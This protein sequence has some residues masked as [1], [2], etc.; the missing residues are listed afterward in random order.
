M[1]RGG[2]WEQKTGCTELLL[3]RSRGSRIWDHFDKPLEGYGP[4]K[5]LR[6]TRM[7]NILDQEN[8]AHSKNSKVADGSEETSQ[9]AASTDLRIK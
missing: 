3:L 6:T 7:V 4:L 2:G 5:A 1:L 9:Y 8:V